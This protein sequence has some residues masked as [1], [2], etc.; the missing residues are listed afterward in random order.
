MR[1]S[2]SVRS[3]EFRSS[4]LSSTN[5][6]FD[7]GTISSIS[8][9]HERNVTPAAAAIGTRRRQG[10]TPPARMAMS[11]WPLESRFNASRMPSRSALGTA[12]A[13]ETRDQMGEGEA[14]RGRVRSL[15]HQQ[16]DI[17]DQFVQQ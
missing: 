9:R 17:P 10:E 5:R 16:L 15:G 6:R 12:T 2:I 13:Q 14:H 7:G 4:S 1:G 3:R 11:S 8:S